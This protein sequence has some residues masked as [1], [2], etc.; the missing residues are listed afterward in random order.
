MFIFFVWKPILECEVLYLVE[1]MS[2]NLFVSVEIRIL[3]A[4]KFQA[5]SYDLTALGFSVV[6]FLHGG[7]EIKGRWGSKMAYLP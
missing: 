2:G 3:K 1:K 4:L 7:I 5:G 6:T